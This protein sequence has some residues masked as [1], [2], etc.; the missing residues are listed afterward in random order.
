MNNLTSFKLDIFKYTLVAAALFEAGS[1]PILGFD[2][3]YSY[4]LALGV[5][6]SV[7]SFNIL[8]F[9]SKKVLATGKKFMAPLGY[10]LRL[11]IYGFAFYVSMKVGTISGI[12]CLLGFFTVT[13]SMIY[14]HGI[15][16]LR[17]KEIEEE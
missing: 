16:R 8:L 6:I 14:V 9:I 3:K 1:L 10:L 12:A 11:P 13:L 15:K 7:I 4:G 5:C 2:I 17:K